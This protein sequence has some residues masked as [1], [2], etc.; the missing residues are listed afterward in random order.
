[1]TRFVVK[2]NAESTVADDPLAAGATTLNVAA[3]GGAS[4]PSAFPFLITLWNEVVYPGP[5]D[6][7]GMEIVKCTGRTT[8]ALTIVRAQ[9]GTADVDH[10]LN[11]RVAMLITAGIINELLTEVVEDTSP[12]LGGILDTNAKQIRE[13]KGS[14]VASAA[15]LTLGTDGNYF[16]I[17]GTTAI[18]SIDTLAVGTIVVLHFDDILTLTYDAT[19]LILPGAANITTAAGDEAVFVEYATG[20]WRCVVYT[21]ASGA[22]ITGAGVP[23]G[24]IAMW[25]GLLADIPSGWVLCDGT[26]STP[27]LRDKFVRG[28]AAAADP[29]TTGGE[30]TH[31][32][33]V[34]EMPAHSHIAYHSS[35][36]GTEVATCTAGYQADPCDVGIQTAGGG[37]A[38]NNIPAY[39]A[40]AYIM[41]T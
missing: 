15:A 13:S 7:P 33:T 21:K 10:T 37:A 23:S 9:E 12:Q 27:D 4:F 22:A 5:T 16:D 31:T 18:T 26:N 2:N 1:M 17:T 35:N 32:L 30:D 6:D 38:H 11:E 24:V 8:D 3:G 20:D 34:S 25:H 19:D 40:I 41:K 14:D 28:A 29:G 39:Y 36:S